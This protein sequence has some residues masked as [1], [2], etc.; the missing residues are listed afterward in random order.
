VLR[1]FICSVFLPIAALVLSPP[2]AHAQTATLTT[3]HDFCAQTNCTD[4]TGGS[5]LLQASDGNF[6]GT[7][8]NGGVGQCATGPGC[9]IIYKVTPRGEFSVLYT[10]CSGGSPC[11]D[12]ADPI[13]SLVQGGDGEL[14]GLTQVGGANNQGTAFKISLSGSLVTLHSFCGQANCADGSGAN[15]LTQGT[16]GNFYGT[17]EN[18]G[19]I[20]ASPCTSYVQGCGTIFQLTPA[21]AFKTIYVFCNTT[22]DSCTDGEF[23][24]SD[25]VQGADGNFYGTTE[26]GGT[27]TSSGCPDS[28]GTVFKVTSGGSLTTIY[29]FCNLSNCTDGY[30]PGGALVQS[31]DGNFY[32]FTV[33]GDGTFFRITPT[34]TV[35][36]LYQFCTGTQ[37]C[38]EGVI[39]YP[40]PVLGADGNFYTTSEGGGTNNTEDGALLQITPTGTLTTLYNFCSVGDDTCTDGASPAPVVQASDG[41]FYGTTRSGGPDGTDGIAYR[42]VVSPAVAAP[43]QLSM[44]VSNVATGSPVTLS[45]QVFNAFSQTMQQCYAFVQNNASGA[46]TWTGLQTGTL[47]NNIYQ[48]SATITPTAAGVYS[49]ALTCGGVETGISGFLFVGGAKIPT[50]TQLSVSPLGVTLGSVVTL[51]ATPS[52]QQNAAPFTGSVTFSY[53]SIKLGTL[54]IANGSAILNVAAQGIPINQTYKI[55]ATYT[56][57]ANYQPSSGTGYVYVEGFT[58]ATAIS[59]SPMTLTQGQ[60]ATLT[61]TIT[62]TASSGVPT[63]GN[64]NFYSLYGGALLGTA[65]ASD[66]KAVFTAS[67]NGSIPPGQ[68]NVSASYLGDASDEPSMSSNIYITVLAATSTTLAVSPNPVPKNSAV[69]L[70][71]HVKQTFGSAIATGAV[72]FSVGNTV[73]GKQTL[74]GTG[75]AVVN[76]SDVG[77]PAGTYPVTAI[78][79]G[80][81]SNAGSQSSPISVVVQ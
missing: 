31:S 74:D 54:P 28:C 25:L 72:T 11:S 79:S 39:P 29:S 44:S 76:A 37:F 64:V 13:G 32:G 62:R 52:T 42:A 46:G 57:D 22:G 8:R 55:T 58:T 16:D 71:S 7:S 61:A 47:Q 6:Y 34:G 45:W 9:G 18:G 43:V 3:I 5:A 59:G 60:A 1:K 12:G 21:G 40:F 73:V 2:H 50:S 81:S 75:T 14:Y 63:G 66:G 35:T 38:R 36:T 26:G 51:T 23:P 70:T 69:T 48:G 56:G 77:I 80:D 49:Y 30:D 65:K 68:Y 33:S 67:T 41:N 10:F 78:Y 15:F 17:T 20:S 24:A 4:G 19:A 27:N 53:G